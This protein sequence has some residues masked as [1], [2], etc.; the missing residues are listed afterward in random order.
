M[1]DNFKDVFSSIFGY[2]PDLPLDI[3]DL[4][5]KLDGLRQVK[6]ESF[7]NLIQK[8]ILFMED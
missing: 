3:P 5:G 1:I 6:K 4:M 7:I 2:E 8:Y